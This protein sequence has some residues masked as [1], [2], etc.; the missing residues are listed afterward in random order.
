[1]SEAEF[2]TEGEA[3]PIEPMK[4]EERNENA[5]TFVHERMGNRLD[6]PVPHDLRGRKVR[7]T[8]EVVNE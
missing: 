8:L 5:F 1:M 4:R 6:M 3:P 7:V 2:H